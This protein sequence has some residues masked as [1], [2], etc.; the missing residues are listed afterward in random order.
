MTEE[1]Y[2]YRTSQNMLR[3]QFPGEGMFQI[4][5]IPKASFSDADF[6]DLRVI[7]FDRT[8]I[9]DEKNTDRMV[10]FFLYDY[11]FERVWK[12]PDR[13][14]EKLRRYRA[15]LSPD[16]SMYLE[17]NPAMQLYNTF[18]NRWC[19]ANFADKGMRVIPTVNWGDESTYD[20]CFL[21]IPKGSTVAV[22]TY[23]VSAHDNR[24]DQKDFFMK[25]YR[26][27]LSRIEPE[28]ILCYHTPF[29][30]MEGNIV[31]IDCE[32]SSWKYQADYTPSPYVKYI[33]GE[34][35]LPKNSGIIVKR[36]GWLIPLEKGTGSAYGG[37]WKP[38]KPEDERLIGKPGEIKVSYDKQGNK[39][40]TKIGEDGRAVAERH[41]T[42]N[43][44]PK[45]HSNPHDHN[46]NW[47]SPH[48]GF[49]N[50]EKAI[51][52]WDNAPEFKTYGGR[53]TMQNNAA[54][55]RNVDNLSSISEFKYK[56]ISGSEFMF[57]WNGIS[58]GVFSDE[59]RYCIAL[60]DGSQE[61][62]CTDVDEVL[63][64]MVGTDRLRD[65]ITQVQITYRTL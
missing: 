13:D 52:Y 38:T 12:E 6:Q 20:F 37:E 10:H 1:N 51:N 30:E 7:G 48:K 33:T 31:Y 42:S 22:S 64:Y 55:I 35:P 19:G 41:H 29:P 47:E 44:N 8:K 45:F 3:N 4:P 26:E 40:E 9:E 14:I 61:K 56:L 50:F 5:T 32:L 39:L 36:N 49:P 2:K 59:S 25:G 23:M 65:V 63:E 60:A 11:K 16:F 53:I 18:R 43:P 58:Y 27:M 46:I 34:L 21:G 15:V 24:A 28:R 17:M 57:S 62:W 54:S